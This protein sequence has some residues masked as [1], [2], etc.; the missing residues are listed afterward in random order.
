M[1]Q[2][3]MKKKTSQT[4]KE[5]DDEPIKNEDESNRGI[6]QKSHRY[7]YDDAHG[8]ENFDPEACEEEEHDETNT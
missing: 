2:M 6:D 3:N 4:S 7:Y 8:Y 5:A 1:S